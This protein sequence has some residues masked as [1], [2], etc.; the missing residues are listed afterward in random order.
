MRAAI[1]ALLVTVAAGSF[2]SVK[3]F[4]WEKDEKMQ[5]E[6]KLWLLAV[7]SPF[8]LMGFYRAFTS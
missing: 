2:I 6:A 4:R 7:L 5:P 1:L 8:L 3:I